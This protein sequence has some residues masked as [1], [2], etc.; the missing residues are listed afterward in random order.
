MS[1]ASE[2]Y[3]VEWRGKTYRLGLMTAAVKEAFVLW[4]EPRALKRAK[5]FLEPEEYLNFREQA[6]GGSIYWNTIA[7]MSVAYEFTNN[8]GKV[9]L[10]RLLFGD[11]IIET[12]PHGKKTTLTDAELLELIQEKEVD[13]SSDYELAMGLLWERENPKAKAGSEPLP[14]PADSTGSLES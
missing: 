9:K 5:R 8:E 2:S 7:C 1:S 11:S 6:T 3:A 4:H 14:V 13:P 10:A 12:D